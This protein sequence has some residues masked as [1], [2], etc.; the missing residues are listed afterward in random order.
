MA[1]FL[2]VI[3]VRIELE[4]ELVVHS[5]LKTLSLNRKEISSVPPQDRAWT[6]GTGRVFLLLK[7]T[8]AYLVKKYMRMIT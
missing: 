3:L 5:R 2:Y 7:L 4:S 8:W 1:V 6:S